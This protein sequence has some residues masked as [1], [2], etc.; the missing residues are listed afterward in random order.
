MTQ[1]KKK[2]IEIITAKEMEKSW[3]LAKK[4]DHILNI[5]K[6]NPEYGSSYVQLKNKPTAKYK[7]PLCEA[8]KKKKKV[9]A[10]ALKNGGYVYTLEEE[11]ES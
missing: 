7:C 3:E 6:I 9:N 11:N 5:S 4:H 8:E 10:V 1:Q 2:E